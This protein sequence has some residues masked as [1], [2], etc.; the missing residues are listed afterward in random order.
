MEKGKILRNLEKLLNRDFEYINAGRILVVANNKNITA[1]LINSMCFKL[2]I[3]PNK[4]YKA[5][6]IKIIDYIKGL[7]TIE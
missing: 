7:E 4:I 5:D 3:D 6:L 2:D 1:D